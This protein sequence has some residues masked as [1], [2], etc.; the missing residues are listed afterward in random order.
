[1]HLLDHKKKVIADPQA[2]V[3]IVE[4]LRAQGCKIVVTIGSWD[5][6]HV[7]HV[8]YLMKAKEEGDVLIVGT[9]SD[10]GIKAY[11]DPSRPMVCQEERLEMLSYLECVDFTIVVDDIDNEGKW[12]YGLINLIKADI[13]VAVEGSYPDEQVEDIKKHCKEVRMLSRQA[14]TSTSNLIHKV[15]KEFLTP[16]ITFLRERGLV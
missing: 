10:R 9:D 16:M 14:E 11:K 1:M 15:M 6:L 7:G 2:L 12:Q 13:F 3:A 8:R 4:G 5:M